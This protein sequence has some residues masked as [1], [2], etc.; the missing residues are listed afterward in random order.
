MGYYVKREDA[1]AALE[2]LA[3]PYYKS[4]LVYDRTICAG[5]KTALREVQSVPAADVRKVV[6]CKN[7]A[8]WKRL[9]QY[10][11]HGAEP[12]KRTCGYF[13][14]STDG[15]DFCSYGTDMREVDDG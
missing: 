15:E 13:S 14:Q 8:W 3:K 1:I 7:C 12:C 5:I 10:D 6:F 9:N 2:N 11:G 4:R